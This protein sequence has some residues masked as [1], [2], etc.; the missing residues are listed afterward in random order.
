MQG[1]RPSRGVLLLS[2]A[3]TLL[4]PCT[5]V[6]SVPRHRH[7]DPLRHHAANPPPRPG[8]AADAIYFEATAVVWGVC[9]LDGCAAD[10]DED[11]AEADED[12]EP[13]HTP[14][15]PSPT[16]TLPAPSLAKGAA[17]ATAR[18]VPL[19]ESAQPA[20]SVDGTAA[21]PTCEDAL[22]ARYGSG[23]CAARV[24]SCDDSGPHGADFRGRRCCATCARA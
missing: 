19:A 3:V 10:E 21:A 18:P 14:P 23:Y 5:E 1:A 7:S 17:P 6:R 8:A 9:T 16:P 20:T 12:G 4:Q 24:A 2:V 22:D 11:S 13:P 15:P